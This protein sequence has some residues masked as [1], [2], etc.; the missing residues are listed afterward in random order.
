[1]DCTYKRPAPPFHFSIST[2]HLNYR[3]TTKW[4]CVAVHWIPI[5]IFDY[6][7]PSLF[8]LCFRRDRYLCSIHTHTE[9]GKK[10]MDYQGREWS[11][12]RGAHWIMML[13]HCVSRELRHTHTGPT[14]MLRIHY[15]IKKFYEKKSKC[16]KRLPT[17]NRKIEK[18]TNTKYFALDNCIE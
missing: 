15:K 10:K 12:Q 13:S 3:S 11:T 7:N 6:T 9:L 17:L 16:G 14:S 2:V 18:A 8:I 4:N 5:P 1:M